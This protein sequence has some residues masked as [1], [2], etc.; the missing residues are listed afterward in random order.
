MSSTEQDVAS[1]AGAVKEKRKA[2]PPPETCWSARVRARRH[3]TRDT[4]NPTTMD[5]DSL[6]SDLRARLEQ[7]G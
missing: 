1:P 5:A 4:S 3:S 7:H 2:R 6:R